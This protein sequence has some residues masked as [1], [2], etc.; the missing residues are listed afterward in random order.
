MLP[1]DTSSRLPGK[2]K[3]LDYQSELQKS[4]IGIQKFMI[5]MSEEVKSL[6]NLQRNCNAVTDAF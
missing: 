5:W 1:S 3:I 2:S 6:Y 4:I